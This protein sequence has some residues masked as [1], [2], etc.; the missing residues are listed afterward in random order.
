M[1][2][3]CT[4]Y[5][6]VTT[7]ISRG[8]SLMYGPLLS[9]CAVF[10]M[11]LYHILL[12]VKSDVW[13]TVVILCCIW[14]NVISYP[15]TGEVWCMV[16]CCHP[17]LYLIWCYIISYYGWSLMYGPLLSSCAVFDIMLYHILLWVKSDVWSTVVILCCIWYNVI[18]YPTTG[19]V[20]CMVH[21][22]HPVL[23]LIWC[24][25]I[26][27]YGWSLMYGPLLSSC[28]VFDIMLYHILL[29]MKSDVWSIFVILCCIWYNVIS[30]PNT[31][32]V[33]CM[34][35]LCHPVLYLI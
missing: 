29:R 23:Y 35:H 8:W 34:V 27:Y 3:L 33:W 11:M 31:D 6:Q 12:R 32:E 20:W 25:I 17:V 4:K 5:S 7:H 16:H 14:Y 18:S 30:Y 19:E 22:C 24:Y 15:T 13:S 2:S 28:A 1:Q 9:S 21:C 10:D 26:S